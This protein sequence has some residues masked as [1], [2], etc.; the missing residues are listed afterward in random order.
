MSRYI[1]LYI[2]VIGLSLS[3]SL[4]SCTDN[5][6]DLSD[7]D[8]NARFSVND[9]IIPINLDEI[10]LD[11]VIDLKTDSKIK[12]ND[13]GYTYI[14][15][16]EFASNTITVKPFTT[17]SSQYQSSKSIKLITDVNT[18]VHKRASE[19]RKP[20][21]HADIRNSTAIKA[22]TANIDSSIIAVDR[23]GTEMN[24]LLTLQFN[25]LT[26]YI[27]QINI[28]ELEIKLLKGLNM[29]SDIGYYDSE[30]GMLNIGDTQTTTDHRLELNL[31]ITGIDAKKTGVTLEN[32]FFNIDDSVYVKSGQLVIYSDQVKDP[33]HPF[34]PNEV[35]YTLS[36]NIGSCTVKSFTGIIKYDITGINIDPIDLSDLPDIL[37]QEGTDLILE[38]PQIYININNPLY[39]KY[40]LFAKAG[41]CLTGNETYKTASDAVVINQAENSFV[42]SPFKPQ[43]LCQGFEHAQHVVFSDLGKVISSEGKK[44]PN[45]VDV[46]LISPMIPEQHVTDFILGDPIQPVK[47]NWMLYAPLTFTSSSIIKYTKTWDDWQDKELDGLTIEKAEVN[48]TISSDVPLDLDVSFTLLGKEGKLTGKATLAANAINSEMNIPL[49][50]TTI[51]KIYG[52]T[53]DVMIQGSGSTISPSQKIVVKNLNAKVSGYYDKEF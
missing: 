45:Q 16:G 5:D 48:A 21:A 28:N 27:H 41:L 10:K 6:Y 38:N 4:T 7:I 22:S 18:N 2:I 11:Y 53:I 24:I 23:V 43:K 13:D 25:G 52:M 39:Q 46:K 1:L 9:L 50:G 32:G 36:A 42:L 17:N 35:D 34:L 20:L 51:S 33:T 26:P 15:D 30:S 31:H 19:N 40:H 37:S 12:K 47:G 44:I 29:T 3:F 49:T 14:V 8:T